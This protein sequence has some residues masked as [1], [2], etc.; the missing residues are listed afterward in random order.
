DCDREGHTPDRHAGNNVELVRGGDSFSDC[1]KQIRIGH[2][3]FHVNIIGALCPGCERKIP[4]F[5]RPV[6]D[7]HLCKCVPYHG[8]SLTLIVN[9]MIFTARW[10]MGVRIR[11]KMNAG[12]VISPK[13]Q[14]ESKMTRR[15]NAP[16]TRSY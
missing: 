2:R 6:P 1:C 5:D 15:R 9:P 8:T 14:P 13:S 7:E 16:A 12:S 10:R 3:R 4:E 11:M